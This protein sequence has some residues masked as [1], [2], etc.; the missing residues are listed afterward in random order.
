MLRVIDFVAALVGLLIFWPVLLILTLVGYFDTGKPLFIQQRIGKNNQPFKLVKFRTMHP[1]TASL[2][3]HLV[4]AK[5]VTPLGNFLRKTKLDELPQLINV[6]LGQMS[7]VGPRP[8]LLNQTELIQERTRRGVYNCRPGITGL[9][10]VNN[11]D[12]STPKKL[13]K[14]DTLMVKQLNLSLYFHLIFKT[15]TGSGQGDKI[16]S[17]TA[18]SQHDSNSEQLETTV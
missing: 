1:E 12:M 10:Q 3:T 18:C 11:I 9:A 8:C 17:S 15:I 5:A 7:L 13:A 2:G 6:L 14:V 4:D 16:H